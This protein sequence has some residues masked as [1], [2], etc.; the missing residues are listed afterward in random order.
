[1][2]K[3]ESAAGRERPLTIKNMKKSFFSLPIKEKMVMYIM[4]MIVLKFAIVSGVFYWQTDGIYWNGAEKNQH[5]DTYRE[6]MRD[7][8]GL[9]QAG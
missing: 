2:E 3:A 6:Y 4:I 8:E 1:M 9:F 5:E 7:G